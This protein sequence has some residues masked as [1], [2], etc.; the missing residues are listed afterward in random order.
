MKRRNKDFGTLTSYEINRLLDVPVLDSNPTLGRLI[1]RTIRKAMTEALRRGEDI[2]IKGFGK[3]K[4]VTR[5]PYYT[6]STYITY[7]DEHGNRSKAPKSP[8]PIY[9]PARKV[10][11]FTPAEQL[12]AMVNAPTPTTWDERR[13]VTLWSDNAD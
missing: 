5:K 12:K 11:T 1:L 9:H 13:A 6:H 7:A 10:V 8:V 3:F 2:H 4:V